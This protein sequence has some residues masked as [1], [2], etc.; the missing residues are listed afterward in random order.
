MRYLTILFCLF[1]AHPAMAAG[2]PAAHVLV[3]SIDGFRPEVYREPEKM[4]IAMPNLTAL[5]HRGVYADR[6]ISVF[7]S[8][9]YPAHTT[10][11]T[12]VEPARHGI[13]SNFRFG[14]FEW[15]RDAADIQAPTLWQAAR[16]TGVTTS[17]IMW[18]MTYGADIDWLIV[19]ADETRKE[20]LRTALT[21][22]AT[23]GLIEHLERKVGPPPAGTRGDPRAI[24]KLDRMS[25]AYAAQI[26]KEHKPGLMVVHFLEADHMQH[27]FGPDSDQARRAFEHIDGL[28]GA[29]IDA[30]KAAGISDRTDVIIVGDHGFAPVHTVINTSRLLLDTGYAELR[31]GVVESDLVTFESQAGSGTFYAKPGANPERLAAF[32][33]KL[34]HQVEQ[35]YRGLLTWLSSADVGRLGGDPSVVG[36]LTAASGYMIANAPGTARYLPTAQFRGMHGYT[37]EM[38]LMDTGMIAAGP[39]FRS[40]QHLPVARL[41]DIAPTIARILKLDLKNTDGDAIVGAL[42]A[43]TDSTS[44]F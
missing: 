28:V 16:K 41:L 9:T 5:A 14:T 4:G 44:V 33:E 7:P 39:S 30:L 27:H 32:R 15:L 20:D 22:G 31:E 17:A 10:I 11:M 25:A 6:V 37:P 19:E 13:M 8:V 34:Q 23:K 36:G 24:E 26:L 40:G 2:A 43:P 29:V 1:I 21:R 3:I 38:P 35:H 12:G 18:P 42:N